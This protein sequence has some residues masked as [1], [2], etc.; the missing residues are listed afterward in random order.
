MVTKLDIVILQ[1][2]GE[3]STAANSRK[4]ERDLTFLL[5]YTA[6]QLLQVQVR[7]LQFQPQTRK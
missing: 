5:E 3:S 7:I 4:S 2:V 6:L 1:L